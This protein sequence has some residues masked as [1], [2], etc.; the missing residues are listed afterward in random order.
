MPIGPIIA[1]IAIQT[2]AMMIQAGMKR[3]I[4]EVT[5]I[6]DEPE[7]EYFLKDLKVDKILTK[8]LIDITRSKSKSR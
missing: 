1:G 3:I 8:S 4:P 2:G 5:K 7:I 6:L